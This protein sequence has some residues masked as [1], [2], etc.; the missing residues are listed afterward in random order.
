MKFTKKTLLFLLTACLSLG[1]LAG[2]DLGGTKGD[3]GQGSTP[4]GQTP[5]DKDPDDKDPDEQG[6]TDFSGYIGNWHSLDGESYL[7][8]VEDDA[9]YFN[10][11]EVSALVYEKGL[12]FENGEVEYVLKHHSVV[13][14]ACVLCFA[15]NEEFLLP[16]AGLDRV[17]VPE[18]L[19]GTWSIPSLTGVFV[20]LDG[21]NFSFT[22]GPGEDVSDGYVVA[23]A[24]E[25]ELAIVAIID[26]GENIGVY[27]LVYDTETGELSVTVFDTTFTF[28]KTG[29]GNEADPRVLEVLEGDYSEELAVSSLQVSWITYYSFVPTYYAYTPQADETYTIWNPY[30]SLS[31]RMDIN[32]S[33]IVYSGLLSDET[34]TIILDWN[35]YIPEEGYSTISLKA[36]VTYRFYVGAYPDSRQPLD[37]VTVSFSIAKGST[38][39]VSSVPIPAKYHGI[40][41]NETDKSK[42]VHFENRR[43]LW[44]G[45]PISVTEA[46]AEALTAEIDGKEATFTLSGATL[47][48]VMEGETTTFTLLSGHTP[49]V[50]AV[51]AGYYMANENELIIIEGAKLDSEGTVLSNGSFT[52]VGHEAQVAAVETTTMTLV[53]GNEIWVAQLDG[54]S[55]TLQKRDGGTPKTF[56][57]GDIVTKFSAPFVGDFTAGE[58][59]LHITS[60][61]V[62]FNKKIVEVWKMGNVL[63]FASEG[64]A[65]AL[66]NDGG[67]LTFT[68]LTTSTP[69]PLTKS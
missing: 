43:A 45:Q 35:S 10:N 58:N 55:V 7:V 47:T 64:K 48:C 38:P 3:D 42:T 60:N 32:L 30:S 31:E 36:G 66:K 2:C 34:A 23:A 51:Y 61:S 62:S 46:T 44:N 29:M 18:E 28:I 27:N 53:V 57:K 1:V 17:S 65:Y 67:T 50:A 8:E 15:E 12:T 4:S 22:P 41:Y 19:N 25:E 40:W 56:V 24:G 5:D 68:D 9:V 37:G 6:S 21:S 13:E 20:T 14:K 69:I 52:W 63:Y 16:E 26:M 39:P 33:L 11:E 54:G 59:T 49:V